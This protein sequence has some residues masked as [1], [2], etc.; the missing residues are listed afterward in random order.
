MTLTDYVSPEDVLLPRLVTSE[1]LEAELE[2][3]CAAI[4]S[5]PRGVIA[6]GKRSGEYFAETGSVQLYT[7]TLQHRR[8]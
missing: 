4:A 1:D 6:L 5:K 3:T 8:K 2:R 7:C